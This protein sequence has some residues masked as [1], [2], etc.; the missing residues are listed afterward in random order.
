MKFHEG[1]EQNEC[2]KLVPRKWFCDG[3]GG[4]TIWYWHKVGGTKAQ[5]IILK[6]VNIEVRECDP[7]EVEVMYTSGMYD[8]TNSYFYRMIFT[9]NV[10][11]S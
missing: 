3:L 7:F 1:E 11:F 6:D 10:F 8:K 5:K 9:N 4:K 2:L